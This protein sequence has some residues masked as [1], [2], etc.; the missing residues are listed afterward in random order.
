MSTPV[1][2]PPSVSNN[3][4]NVM[5]LVAFFLAVRMCGEYGYEGLKAVIVTTIAYAAAVLALEVIFLRTPLRPST[6]L[7]FSDFNWSTP[8]ILYKLAGLYGTYGLIALLYWVF[9]EYQGEFYAGFMDMLIDVLPYLMLLAIPYFALVDSFMKEPEDNYYWFGRLL[10][11]QKTT[12]TRRAMAQHLLGWLV[13]GFFYPLMFSYMVEDIDYFITFDLGEEN[14][15]FMN[16]YFPALAL[17]FMMDLLA[18]VAGYAATFRLFDTHIRSAEPTLFGWVVCLMC[19]APFRDVTLEVYLAYRDDGNYW[20]TWF[21]GNETM[22]ILWGALT[23]AAVIIYSLASLNFGCRFSNLTHRGILTNGMYRFTKH[24]AYISK[25]FLW[26]ITFMPFIPH[27][28]TWLNA[29]QFCFTMAGVNAV[30]F[31]RARTEE[32]HLSHDRTYV[33]YALWINEHGSLRW[34]GKYIPFFRYKPPANWE[35]LPEMYKG[36]K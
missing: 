15:T 30:Y 12:T 17:I 35:S 25:N 28:D 7:D 16:L 23:I 10:L 27:G 18:A 6:G 26:W 31:L 24:P 2:L 5:G 36:L 14:I 11:L 33:E 13:K 34:L 1:K 22:T 29:L 3:L 9:P 21:D 20:I 19:Y 4:I 32:R 8:R